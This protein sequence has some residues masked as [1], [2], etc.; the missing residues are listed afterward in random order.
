MAMQARQVFYVHDPCDSRWSVVLQ[1][2][3]ISIS[4]QI[5]CSSVV[6]S[7]MLGFCQ[8][9]PFINGEDQEDVVH[10]NRNDHGEGLWGNSHM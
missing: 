1:W 10:A 6:M 7:E 9:M 4:D 2:R 8:Q 5:D 3:T